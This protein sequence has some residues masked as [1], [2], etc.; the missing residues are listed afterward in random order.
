MLRD[1]LHHV[2]GDERRPIRDQLER[3]RAERVDVSAVIDLVALR[4]LRRQVLRRADDRA[5]GGVLDALLRALVGLAELG[6]AEVE[7][8]D[9][10]LLAANVDEKHVIGLEIAMNDPDLVRGEQCTRERAEQL[11]DLGD[12]D[13][14][15]LASGSQRFAAQPLH[16]EVVAAVG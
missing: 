5:G 6:D 7:E 9:E 13:P 12:R 4:L 14:F 15:A 8:L 3:D 16:H 10:R 1:H 2:V 11:A